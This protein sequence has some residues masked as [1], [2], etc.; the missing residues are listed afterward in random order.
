MDTIDHQKKPA[1]AD[2]AQS[3]DT[4]NHA[5]LPGTQSNDHRTHN[6]FRA[7]A[8][9]IGSLMGGAAILINWTVKELF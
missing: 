5:S 9:V 3:V 1:D 6:V 4:E 7:T 2:A 8:I